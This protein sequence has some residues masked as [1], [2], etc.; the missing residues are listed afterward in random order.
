[1]CLYYRKLHSDG[2]EILNINLSIGPR[3]MVASLV[4]FSLYGLASFVWWYSFANINAQEKTI[5]EDTFPGL[6]MAKKLNELNDR[7]MYTA[8]LMSA[9][10]NERE[11]SDNNNAISKLS[12][13]LHQIITQ[14]EPRLKND[15]LKITFN[16]F[17]NEL[18]GVSLTAH[19]LVSI[20][21]ELLHIG[22]EIG[23]SA[24]FISEAAAE[25]S[26]K[27][28]YS[29]D[30]S[31]SG[32]NLL[33][34]TREN[35]EELYRALNYLRDVEIDMAYQMVFI[36]FAGRSMEVQLNEAVRA[37]SHKQVDDYQRHI[38]R[39][40]LEVENRVDSILDPYKKAK[41]IDATNRIRGN[42]EVYFKLLNARI[43]TRDQITL[44]QINQTKL[45]EEL[46]S[47]VETIVR[48]AHL[49]AKE[50][51]ASVSKITEQTLRMQTY[52]SIF[53]FLVYALTIRD[54]Y[55]NVIKRL[56]DMT[57]AVR[58]LA[59]GD[60]GVAIPQG[61][62]DEISELSKALQV[63]KGTAIELQVHQDELKNIVRI[64]TIQL[65]KA[66]AAL[67]K[68][69]GEHTKARQEA[70]TANR[71]KSAFLA[72][73]SHE[74]RTPMNGIVGTLAL[75]EETPLNNEQKQYALTISKSGTI[76]MGILNNVLDYSK[77]ETGHF[78]LNEKSFCIRDTIEDV[79]KMMNARAQEKGIQMSFTVGDQIPDWLYGDHGKLTQ[80]LLNLV[81]NS[82]KF[83]DSGSVSIS[84]QIRNEPH[85]GHGLYSFEVL[86]TG[87][88]ISEHELNK[89]FEPFEQT[90]H[91]AGGTGL[92]LAIS[93]RFT[94][95][96][97]GDLKVKSELGKCTT[98]E[99]IIPLK[100]GEPSGQKQGQISHCEKVP[101]LNILLVEDNDTNVMVAKGF[102]KKL[103]HK[104]TTTMNGEL[105]R[106]AIR[107]TE[108]DMI[109]MDINLPDIDG[110]SLTAELRDIAKRRIPTIAFSAH[111]FRHEVEAYLNAGLDGFIGK[112]VKIDV[113]TRTISQVY[114]LEKASTLR[115]D[116][117][118]YL[119]SATEVPEHTEPLY[120]PAILNA[121]LSVLGRE[122]VI[123]IVS[124]FIEHTKF[125]Y[126][127]ILN[128]DNTYELE[129][130]AHSLKSSS[131]TVGLIALEKACEALERACRTDE[132]ALVID[133]HVK[134]VLLLYT[135]SVDLL[136]KEFEI[137]KNQG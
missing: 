96:L 86:D 76:L 68:E 128:E 19:R 56:N 49:D 37:N 92:G 17:V 80:I 118:N 112:P 89:I 113:L 1:M 43:Q 40:L 11:L 117:P 111:V 124:T 28:K 97:G 133:K 130:A 106:K 114:F 12:E 30:S 109:L 16:R 126:E 95:M 20:E 54:I 39:L 51:I 29:V 22:A 31:I 36:S 121:D 61:G 6:L 13:D 84:V 14:L 66:N 72:H 3:L 53:F 47:K 60:L 79:M 102:L 87:T 32:L 74:I 18:N 7:L 63:F 129:N 15:Y 57:A 101:K 45:L 52:F 83:S 81:G 98:F 46:S 70:E 115:S 132:N 64:R 137:K 24:A 88:G 136:A 58:K 127:K 122:M 131:G 8:L 21:N 107:G 2:E 25:E 4:I 41:L 44:R 65:T 91:S 78:E 105:A 119:T 62:E 100:L 120:D 135:P 73:M 99:F 104:V 33:I 108:F 110:V 90:Q 59:N 116:E 75:L 23:T 125:L 10:D 38:L 134:S 34:Q 69:V 42:S 9:A 5:V 35:N 48:N 82:I 85:D 50:S 27:A 103:G 93:Q 123:E 77:I 71:A 55:Q 94:A 67:E 26:T